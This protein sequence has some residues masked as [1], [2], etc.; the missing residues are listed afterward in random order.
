LR[1]SYWVDKA[2]LARSSPNVQAELAS[3][4]RAAVEGYTEVTG[5]KLQLLRRGA[6]G[7]LIGVAVL[8]LVR[9]PPAGVRPTIVMRVVP[10]LRARAESAPRACSEEGTMDRT[11]LSEA[12]IQ[13]LGEILAEE[14]RAAGPELLTA[15]LD[16]MEMRLQALSR[17]VCGATLERVLAV[18]AIPQG[19]R[20]PCPACGGLLQLVEQARGRDLQG[21]ILHIPPKRCIKGISRAFGVSECLRCHETAVLRRLLRRGRPG[22]PQGV[23]YSLSGKSSERLRQPLRACLG[24]FRIGC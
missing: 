5:R 12:I 23:P 7:L 3:A 11:E 19:E 10:Y 8:V 22:V 1:L 21:G 17:R 14:L 2:T 20:P 13:E 18:R 15:D 24:T 6:V 9:R 16:G 4:Y